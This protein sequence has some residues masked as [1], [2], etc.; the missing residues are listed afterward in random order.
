VGILN[1]AGIG[2]AG[3][4]GAG[5]SAI[6][7]IRKARRL[8]QVDGRVT[9]TAVVLHPTDAQKV[10]LLKVNAEVNHFVRDPFAPAGLM[11]V[12]GMP[13]VETT[14]MPAGTGL[15]GDFRKAILFDRE[16]ATVTIGTVGDDFIRNPTLC[17]HTPWDDGG[18][19]GTT[20]DPA[21]LGPAPM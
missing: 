18:R 7:Q 1:T 10:D 4:P 6:D 3:A 5:E 21:R 16:Q 14:A 13:V 8:V 2:A 12:Y 20:R 15:V 9:P 17:P 11:V 19:D